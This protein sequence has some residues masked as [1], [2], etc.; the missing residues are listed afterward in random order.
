MF[1]DGGWSI[2]LSVYNITIKVLNPK[3][4]AKSIYGVRTTF[5]FFAKYPNK[6]IK[7]IIS[8]GYCNAK[9]LMNSKNTKKIFKLTCNFFHQN[10][11]I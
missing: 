7:D 4:F 3:Y 8:L 9:F 1:K 6:E 10:M 5:M 2:T 11:N